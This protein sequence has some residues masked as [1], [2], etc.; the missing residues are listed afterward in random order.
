MFLGLDPSSSKVG[1]CVTLKGGSILTSGS[2]DVRGHKGKWL[3]GE[4]PGKL[5]DFEDRLAGF[6]ASHPITDAAVEQLSVAHNMDTVR[7]IA[8]FEAACLMVC[9]R[10]IG[11]VHSVKTTTARK[12]VLGHGGLSKEKAHPL[13]E[14]L[15]GRKLDPDEA[16]AYLFALYAEAMWG[17]G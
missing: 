1:M 9:W 13:L 10:G 5:S 17:R 6:I 7:K 8:Y 3:P 2:W 4:I 16:D 15:A 11:N 12:L 14:S